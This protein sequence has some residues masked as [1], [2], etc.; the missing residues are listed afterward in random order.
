MADTKVLASVL[1]DFGQKSGPGAGSELDY[2][3]LLADV[4]CNLQ[5]VNRTVA[6]NN[7]HRLADSHDI[8]VVTNHDR[9]SEAIVMMRGAVLVELIESIVKAAVSKA[10][11]SRPLLARL[12]GLKPVPAGPEHAQIRFDTNQVAHQLHADGKSEPSDR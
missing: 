3:A 7:F 5:K 8:T 2:D 11:R 6:R 9:T 10:G 12:E 4:P 1:T